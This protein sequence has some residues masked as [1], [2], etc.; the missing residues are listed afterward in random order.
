MLALGEALHNVAVAAI[1]TVTIT[2]LL[3]AAIATVAVA[4][5]A[6]AG[7]VPIKNPT[8]AA[9]RP[10]VRLK[11]LQCAAC[12]ASMKAYRHRT[13]PRGPRVVTGYRW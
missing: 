3:T 2:T 11:S 1:T 5:T 13:D 7:I 9:K 10:H 4:T 6:A 8:W 12:T